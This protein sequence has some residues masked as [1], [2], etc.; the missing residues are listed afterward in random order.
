MHRFEMTSLT[1]MFD[2]V[3]EPVCQ[4]NS[5]NSSSSPPLMISSQTRSISCPFQAGRQPGAGI[6][7]RGGLLHVAVGVID[8]DR[9][10]VPADVEVLE[11][12]L[13]LRAPVTV[14]GHLDVA[15]TLEFAPHPR[16]AQ[17]NREVKD[18]GCRLIRFRHWFAASS[19]ASATVG[20]VTP[21]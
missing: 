4:T 1:F 21:S 11:T 14:G 8:L 18:R 19:L 2:G 3:P 13:G 12:P 6:H 17:A 10:P 20:T 16:G 7:H 5:G 15:G 9:H